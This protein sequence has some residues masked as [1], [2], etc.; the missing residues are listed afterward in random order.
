MAEVGKR[1]DTAI[2]IKR[3]LHGKNYRRPNLTHIR[4]KGDKCLL[5]DEARA[6]DVAHII[7]VFLCSN[8]D[9]L[10]GFVK[11]EDNLVIL[12]KN[13]HYCFDNALLTDSELEKIYRKKSVFLDSV[14]LNLANSELRV[15]ERAL[16]TSNEAMRLERFKAWIKWVSERIFHKV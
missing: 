5:C 3:E 11:N 10:K 7:P 8:T 2:R 9:D 12:C 16:V 1:K 15:N 6:I 14:F 4:Q 13:H